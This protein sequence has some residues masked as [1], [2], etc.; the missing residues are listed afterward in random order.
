MGGTDFRAGWRVAVHAND[1]HGLRRVSPI[2]VVKLNHRVA[3]VRVALSA[4]LHTRVAPDAATRIDVKITGLGGWHT[5][6]TISRRLDRRRFGFAQTYRTYLVLR[7]VRDR[8]LRGDRQLV[9][10]SLPCPV[11][12][13]KNRIRPNRSHHTNFEGDRA[14]PGFR[15]SPVALFESKFSSKDRVKTSL[16]GLIGRRRSQVRPIGVIR[17][18]TTITLAPFSRAC[19]T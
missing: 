14:T 6:L 12:G 18:S 16:P 1:R 19:Q 13:N 2:D 4:S 15:R 8:I 17:G 5:L 10:A 7:N 11:I 9:S 3:L